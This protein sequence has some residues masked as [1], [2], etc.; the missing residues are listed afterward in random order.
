M[1]DNMTDVMD[2]ESDMEVEVTEVDYPMDG[3]DAE[4]ML[5]YEEGAQEMEVE[6][7]NDGVV[8]VEELEELGG[9]PGY[10]TMTPAESVVGTPAESAFVGGAGTAE[11]AFAS[12][13]AAE[14]SAYSADVG[15][16]SAA[17]SAGAGG[18]GGA[19]DAGADVGA[20]PESAFPPGSAAALVDLVGADSADADSELYLDPKPKSASAHAKPNPAHML[21]LA[22]QK[23]DKLPNQQDEISNGL[24]A[25]AQTGHDAVAGGH[26]P[27]P[28]TTTEGTQQG[29]QDGQGLEDV[30]PPGLSSSFNDA[31]VDEDADYEAVDEPTDAAGPSSS[32][33]AAHVD[34]AGAHSAGH[35]VHPATGADAHGGLDHGTAAHD[36]SGAG[37]AGDGAAYG[38]GSDPA[39]EGVQLAAADVPADVHDGG[40]AAGAPDAVHAAHDDAAAGGHE[41]AAADSV[42]HVPAAAAVHGSNEPNAGEADGT[43]DLTAGE[44]DGPRDHVSGEGVDTHVEQAAGQDAAGLRGE[45]DQGHERAE[46]ED[47]QLDDGGEFAEEFEDVEA[48][49]DAAGGV[50]EAVEASAASGGP[51]ALALGVGA[52]LPLDEA[53]AEALQGHEEAAAAELSTNT[54][55]Y[56]D[57]S[58]D[59]DLSIPVLVHFAETGKTYLVSGE[60]SDYPSLFEDITGS[61]L[62]EYTMEEVFALIRRSL[63][64]FCSMD[65]ELVLDCSQIGLTLGEDNVC[66]RDATLMDLVRLFQTFAANTVDYNRPATFDMHLTLSQRFI[67]NYN[68]LYSLAQQGHGLDSRE[69]QESR[70]TEPSTASTGNLGAE[71]L[72]SNSA[73]LED[74]AQVAQETLRQQEASLEFAKG[75]FSNASNVEDP[76]DVLEP[77]LETNYLKREGSEL[78]GEGGKKSRGE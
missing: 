59:L 19:G 56:Y 49:E 36:S 14:S 2:L 31:S 75:A 71:I 76:E 9:T 70:V 69:L 42:A 3:S 63:E 73:A 32:H 44:T 47:G 54:A 35:S 53:A 51:G 7:D 52:D 20:A 23:K 33:P 55:S 41:Q 1:A 24:G 25:V 5:E 22:Q 6:D 4:D 39:Q 48:V 66:S 77:V 12:E 27:G 13:A 61:E 78:E 68:R 34:P 72:G 64:G 10:L 37:G 18:A 57:Q 16:Y 40:A 8:D 45:I 65:E 15:A 26:A 67:S 62:Q 60:H 11:S 58:V 21:H 17:E 46:A 28:Q 50:D 43:V 74:E 29:V 30:P 38:T